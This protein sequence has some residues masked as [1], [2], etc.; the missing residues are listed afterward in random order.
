MK[1]KTDLE[2]IAEALE[3]AAGIQ[4]EDMGYLDSKSYLE[5]IAD[6]AEIVFA[7]SNPKPDP[8]LQ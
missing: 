3:R 8:E 1:D 6:A 5:R 4:H 7:G 2:R